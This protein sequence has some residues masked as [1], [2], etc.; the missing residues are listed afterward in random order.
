VGT[1]D[2][3]LPKEYHRLKTDGDSL[4]EEGKF[5]AAKLKLEAALEQLNAYAR[6]ERELIQSRLF[7][8]NRK[9]MEGFLAKAESLRAAGD[10]EAANKALSAALEA[11]PD[12]T[13][14]DRV[15]L[16]RSENAEEKEPDLSSHLRKLYEQVQATPEDPNPLYNFG[17]ELALDGYLDA[18]AA[19]FE[20]VVELTESDSEAQAVACFRLGNLYQDLER[21]EEAQEFLTRALTLGYDA[22]DVHFRLGDLHEWLGDIEKAREQYQLC[23]KENPEHVSALQAMGKSHAQQEEFAEALEFFQQAITVDPEDSETLLRIGLIFA[24]VDD[25]ES[26]IQAFE[27]VIEVDPESEFAEEAQAQIEE[28][29]Q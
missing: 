10:S 6:S 22:G 7:Q 8:A 20:R 1:L 28:L 26:A 24:E 25:Q 9:V 11:A 23:L 16:A 27:A 4:L 3:S 5:A 19:Q 21:M 12:Q 2:Q 17:I 29:T 15:R 14:R 13:A 18:A